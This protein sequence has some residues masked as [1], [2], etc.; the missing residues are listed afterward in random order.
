MIGRLQELG[1]WLDEANWPRVTCP[2]CERG[3]VGFNEAEHR[4]DRE[5]EKIVDRTSRNEGPPDE[6][7]GT[8]DGSLKCDSASC[9]Q[10]LS[11][12]GDWEL[13]FDDYGDLGN[14]YKIRYVNPPLKLVHS[15]NGTPPS[16]NQAI[17]SASEVVWLSPSAAANRLRHAVEELLTA[18]RVKKTTKL[19][20][21]SV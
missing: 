15:P 3:S 12:A 4:L 1:D 16:V 13:L 2:V 7:A 14:L 5:S 18:L 6:L 21:E 19:R 9:G 20:S 11:M 10:L 17:K 8:F